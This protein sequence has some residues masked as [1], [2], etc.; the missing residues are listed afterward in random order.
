MTH[1]FSTQRKISCTVACKDP[2]FSAELES[3]YY[4]DHSILMLPLLPPASV[5]TD[6]DGSTGL[7]GAPLGLLI[8]GGT[9][10]M[11][12]DVPAAFVDHLQTATSII[13]LTLERLRAASDLSRLLLEQRMQRAVLSSRQEQK[14]HSTSSADS[15]CLAIRSVDLPTA[16]SILHDGGASKPR[17][18][19]SGQHHW[20][21]EFGCCA[22]C[23]ER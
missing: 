4:N 16:A 5:M 3:P 1:A 11:L 19:T 7:A 22:G 13:A 15:L 18:R 2:K 8:L 21:A 12:S 17:W 23:Q 20:H 10:R 6:T 14:A 9:P